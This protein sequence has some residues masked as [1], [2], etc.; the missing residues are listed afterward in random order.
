MTQDPAWM[1]RI[2]AMATRLDQITQEM[3]RP[4]IASNGALMVK[5][6]Q[7]L[8]R[9]EKF[10][11]PY[12][13]YRDLMRQVQEMEAILADS[14]ADRDLRELA[15]AELPELQSRREALLQR[16][17]ALLVT[18]DEG[19]IQSVIVEIRAGTGGDEAALFAADL[20]NMYTNYAARKGYKT[21]LMSLSESELGGVREA[22]LNVTGDEV[23]L[24]FAYEGGGHRVQRV[25]KTETQ[26]RI[27]TSL[28]TVAVLPE[29]DEVAVEI[30]WDK[31]VIEH[32]SAAGGPGGQ[33]VNKVASA[34][35]L[36]H[37]PTGITVSMRDERSQH[38]NRARARRVMMSR[39][40][41]HYQRAAHAKL[42]SER[43]S[44]IGSGDR[45]DR[46]RTYNFPQNR[47][48]DHR[49]GK[50]IFDIPRVLSGDL[51]EF[52]TELRNWDVR[53]RLEAMAAE[54]AGA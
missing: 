16:L 31:D 11:R 34:I 27:H 30:D 1:P 6:G 15:E 47:V 50:D 37:I 42:S 24:N 28:A 9:L 35:K 17:Q 43:K 40:F 48:T 10:V 26:G 52:V 8:G 14:G 32:V 51:D 21:E 20:L 25:P 49:I 46:I 29:P 22:I 4:E 54:P 18:G 45:S 5:L 53:M 3:N 33:N 12:R 38:K 39:V 13:E 7:E 23:Y 44:M 2:A 41:E 19:A 36:E